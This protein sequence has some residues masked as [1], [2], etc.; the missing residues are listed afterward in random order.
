MLVSFNDFGREINLNVQIEVGPRA[1]QPTLLF[2]LSPQ[3][4]TPNVEA[5]GASIAGL[6]FES[7]NG[8]RDSKERLTQV[9]SGFHYLSSLI[10]MALGVVSCL[11]ECNTK[12]ANSGFHRQWVQGPEAGEG[13]REAEG[14]QAV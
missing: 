5:F 6:E 10:L 12:D 3:I 7:Y 1:Y 9:R 13:D 8:G 2:L 14:V 11:T 4:D